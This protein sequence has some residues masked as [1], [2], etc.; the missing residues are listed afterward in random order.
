MP[1]ASGAPRRLGGLALLLCVGAALAQAVAVL[2]VQR[3]G[4]QVGT[5]ELIAT[6]Q[7]LQLVPRIEGLAPGLWRVDRVARCGDMPPDRPL[8]WLWADAT[9]RMRLPVLLTQQTLPLAGVLQLEPP[10]GA[11]ADGPLCT[12]LTAGGRVR[13]SQ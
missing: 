13:Q 6:A 11:G 3:A 4:E 2:P 1:V 5:L 12:P 8:T 7:G 10:G 9:G